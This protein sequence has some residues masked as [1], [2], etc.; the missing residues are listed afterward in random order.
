MKIFEIWGIKSLYGNNVG[1]DYFS[2]VMTFLRIFFLLCLIFVYLKSIDC[3]KKVKKKNDMWSKFGRFPYVFYNKNGAINIC[4]GQ[5][6]TRFKKFY[7]RKKGF[8]GFFSDSIP[9]GNNV[10][11]EYFPPAMSFLCILF[12]CVWCCMND[13]MCLNLFSEYILCL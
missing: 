12:D 1:L 2:S 13:F 4:E 6:F 9:Y 8:R 7:G 11:L 5:I 3:E 10:G